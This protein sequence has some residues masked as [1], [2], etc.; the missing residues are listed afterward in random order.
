MRVML[1]TNIIVSAIFFPSHQ[2]RQFIHTLT[3]NHQIILCDYVIEELRA[4]TMRKFPAKIIDMEQFFARLP[5]ELV[6]TPR[7][8]AEDEL[9]E[10]RDP[11]DAPILASAILENI[12]VFVTGDVDFLCLDLKSPEIL[13]MKSFLDKY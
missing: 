11:K 10:I 2:T 12:D 1:D 9:P 4:V 8:S 13:N 5:F 7:I 6:C 3:E